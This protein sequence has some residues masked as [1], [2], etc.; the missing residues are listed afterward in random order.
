MFQSQARCNPLCDSAYIIRSSPGSIVS[1]SSEMQSPLRPHHSRHHPVSLDLFQSQARCNPLCD[2]MFACLSFPMMLFQS[3]A[4]CN[5]LCDVAL[6]LA[7]SHLL[8]VSISSEMQSP[9]RPLIAALI[10]GATF[11]FNLKR[12]AIPF[13]TVIRTCKVGL[14]ASFNLKRDAIPFATQSFSDL[15]L[16]LFMFQSQARCNPLCDFLGIGDGWILCMFQSQARCNPLCDHNSPQKSL[17]FYSFNLKR[18][19]IPF[20]TKYVTIAAHL[21]VDVSIINARV[22]LTQERQ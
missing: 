13:A 20:A 14:C 12:D 10:V 17:T 1:I 8:I 11:S 3:Q 5:P 6:L 9:L 4:R 18:D 19:A 16:D 22:Q 7:V 21:S 2:F 15:A